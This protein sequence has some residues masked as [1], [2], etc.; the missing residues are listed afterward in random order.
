MTPKTKKTIIILSAVV[1][2]V[3]IVWYL[4]SWKKSPNGIVSRLDLS[5]IDLAGETPAH[6]RKRIRAQVSAVKQSFTREEISH[7]AQNDGL[8]YNQELVDWGCYLLK[9]M[10]YLNQTAYAELS[11]QIKTL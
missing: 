10:G 1:A 11:R 7:Q 4:F 8:T 5:N 6:M 2:I 3:G 9:Q